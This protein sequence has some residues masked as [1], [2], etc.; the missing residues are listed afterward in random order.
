MEG[1]PLDLSW[2]RL[3]LSLDA[4]AAGQD[5]AHVVSSTFKDLVIISVLHL[6]LPQLLELSIEVLLVC[7]IST[8]GYQLL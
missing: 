1:T 4:L 6:L 2:L 8:Q 5:G 7:V 3:P